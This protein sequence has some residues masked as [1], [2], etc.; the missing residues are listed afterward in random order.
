MELRREGGA[1]ERRGVEQPV[2]A[3][4]GGA[5]GGPRRVQRHERCLARGAEVPAEAR[6]PKSA[7]IAKPAFTSAPF[8]YDRLK[9]IIAS[10]AAFSA[11]ET[12]SW[13]SARSPRGKAIGCV[14]S[15][16]R[17]RSSRTKRFF[18]MALK[19]HEPFWGAEQLTA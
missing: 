13:Y 19:N 18:F 1:A 17:A 2:R 10:G 3:E 4:L 5:R 11:N 16:D 12:S 7:R 15:A 14:V 6:R 8:T 9:A